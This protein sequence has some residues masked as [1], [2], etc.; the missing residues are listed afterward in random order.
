VRKQTQR[1]RQ[2]FD[3]SLDEMPVYGTMASNF[4][5]QGVTSLYN[6]LFTVLE[7]FGLPT[8]RP[9]RKPVELTASYQRGVVPTSRQRY[10]SEI[11]EAVRSYQDRAAQQAQI[12]REYQQLQASI[13]ML[14]Q[15]GKNTDELQQLANERDETLSKESKLHLQAFP[16]LIEDYS[17]SSLV[18]SV[19]D[20]D[21]TQPLTHTSLSGTKVPRISL[22]RYQDHGDILRWLML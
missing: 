2:A 20:R 13:R 18:Y 12:A 9:D 10:L 17:G 16:K 5:D 6:E 15:Q 19:R 11:A 8:R 21:I 1:N 14:G 22:P 3:Q 4:N 7:P